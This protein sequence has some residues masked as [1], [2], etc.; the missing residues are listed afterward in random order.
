MGLPHSG[1]VA[2]SAF[3]S[4]AE[5]PW[6]VHPHV[7]ADH[8]IDGYWRFRND[9]LILGNDMSRTRE[10]FWKLREL[11]GFFRVQCESWSSNEIQFLEVIVR[12]DVNNNWYVT[13]PKYCGSSISKPLD[14]SS[15]HPVHVHRSWPQALA[16]R[17]MFLTCVVKQTA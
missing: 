14:P 5:D 1:E 6:V 9:I 4:L 12:R 11:A 16:P 13:I 2:D 3:P 8:G 17:M 15:A 10:Y 7:Q